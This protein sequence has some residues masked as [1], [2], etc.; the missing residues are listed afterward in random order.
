MLADAEVEVA[1]GAIVRLEVA[2]SVEHNTRLR[3]RRE[4]GGAAEEPGHVLGNRVQ[5]LSRRVA[6]RDALGIGW[7]DRDVGVPAHWELASLHA[8]ELVG[9]IRVGR[10]ILL[11]LGFPRLA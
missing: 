5:H 8:L 1:P 6:A 9:E 4:V 10:A 2:G 3:R 7:E 11:E